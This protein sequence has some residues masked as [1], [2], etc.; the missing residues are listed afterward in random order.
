MLR[1][2]VASIEVRSEEVEK[3][4]IA[5]ALRQAEACVP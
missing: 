3:K 1:P 5:L 2:S 4:V